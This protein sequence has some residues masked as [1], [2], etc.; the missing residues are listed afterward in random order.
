MGEG[1]KPTAEDRH[2]GV[3]GPAGDSTSPRGTS[4]NG[5]TAGAFIRARRQRANLSLQDLAIRVGCARSYVSAIETGQR[6]A[7]D[8]VLT[9]V[10]E[11]LMIPTGELV[12]MARWERSLAA[13][14]EDVRRAMA[15]LQEDQRLARRL[16]ALLAERRSLDEAF[17]SGELRRVV[18]QLE[19]GMAGTGMAMGDDGEPHFA[20]PAGA[21]S[22][23]V[24]P[25]MLNM[26]VP[27][28][29]K[30]A[31]GYPAEFTDLSYPARVAD[32]YVK[33]PDLR[34]PDAFAAR[35]VGD[36]ML[37]VYAEGDIVI[38]SPSQPVRSGM[39]CFARLEPDHATTFKRVYFEKDGDREMIRLQPLN[40]AYPPRVVEREGVAGL[41]PA[42]SVM[43]KV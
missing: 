1:R 25:V 19:H 13:G 17:K 32:E 42:V 36:S 39:D 9:R 10:E 34:D 38:F 4:L 8:E 35:V 16:I 5:P 6:H 18:E 2:N 31:A 28:I 3:K 15:R 23:T 26:D 43:R 11:A 12:R 33:C 27:L 41:Y 37:P 7:S 24:V 22:P 20:D 14:G 21:F 30:V 40:A 29:N